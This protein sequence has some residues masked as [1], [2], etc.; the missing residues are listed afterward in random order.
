[1]CSGCIPHRKSITDWYSSAAGAGG[2]SP[3]GW[4]PPW[5]DS[6]SG[7]RDVPGRMTARS[8]PRVMT[9]LSTAKS[10][11]ANESRRGSWHVR[12]DRPVE[13]VLLDDLRDRAGADGAA[14]FTDREA[15]S[16]FDGDRLDQRDRHLRGVARHDHLGALRKLDNAGHI[17]GAEEELRA[18]VVEERRVP[19]ALVLAQDVDRRLELRVRGDRAG[20]D[21]NLAALD[22]FPL[23]ATKQQTGVVAGGRRIEQLAEHLDA[24][25]GG[26]EGLRLDAD[27]FHRGVDVDRATLHLA[28]DDGATTGDR[29]DVLDRHQERLLGVADRLWDGLVHGVHQLDNRRD[30]LRVTLERL[31]AGGADDRGVLIELLG[32]QQLAN[33]ELDE[34]QDLLVVNHV[35]L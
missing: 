17:G 24:G 25:D 35:G 34:L 2:G 33:L 15:E 22:V 27:D 11:A 20:L 28:G 23:G 3:N 19:S 21:D 4:I 32:G 13:T 14:T 6:C 30:P 9:V 12:R 7:S 8:S 29:E 16:L 1:M 31:E 10:P 18:V 5:L 26:L